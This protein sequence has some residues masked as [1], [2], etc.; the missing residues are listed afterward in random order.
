MSL[1]NE[2][3]K[4]HNFRVM[5]SSKGIKQ[6][7]IIVEVVEEFIR[8]VDVNSGNVKVF[9]INNIDFIKKISN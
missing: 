5:I 6:E 8:G 4:L 7:I 9:P 1:A 2:V 3:R